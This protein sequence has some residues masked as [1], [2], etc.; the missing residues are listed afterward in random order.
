MDISLIS[1]RKGIEC[2]LFCLKRAE[3]NFFR[4]SIIFI[5]THPILVASQGF[6]DRSKKKI[7]HKVKSRHRDLILCS[8]KPLY[9]WPQSSITMI[10][11][12]LKIIICTGI[13]YIYIYI[14]IYLF[15]V[16]LA[17]LDNQ[18]YKSIYIWISLF[19]ST[20]FIIL[21]IVQK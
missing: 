3:A 21:I 9:S 8:K 11:T 13:I 12:P 2:Y 10:N 1:L 5:Y 20:V 14:F 16:N 15:I 4:G 19:S 17:I 7:R 6:R 18:A